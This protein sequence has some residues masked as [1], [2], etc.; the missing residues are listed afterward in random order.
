MKYCTRCKSITDNDKAEICT[1]CRKKLIS[2]PAP[3]SPVRIITAEGFEFQRICAALDDG[4]LPYSYSQEK[5]DALFRAAVP[6]AA[7]YNEIFVPLTYYPDAQSILEEIGAKDERPPV[8][9]SEEDMQRLERAKAAENSD[10]MS[11]GK[12]RAIRIVSGIGFL[13]ILA[14]VAF[15]TDWA[16]A[17]IKALMIHS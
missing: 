9:L 1:E 8:M 11:P 10:E 5:N 12:A 7:A 6:S 4:K 13:L 2:D 15:A 16:I 17:L 14:A 3:S